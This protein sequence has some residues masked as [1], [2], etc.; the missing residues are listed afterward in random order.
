MLANQFLNFQKSGSAS[1]PDTIGAVT[2]FNVCGCRK[3]TLL[4]LS[5]TSRRILVAQL[6]SLDILAAL[7]F[8][9]SCLELLQKKVSARHVRSVHCETTGEQIVAI[10]Q[11]RKRCRRLKPAAQ[12]QSRDS[13]RCD[14][15][16]FDGQKCVGPTPTLSH[17]I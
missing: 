13:I 14:V 17:T 16:W 12:G 2:Y 5:T 11:K 7:L 9:T 4:S 3:L 15:S 8:E 6:P 1:Q 10:A